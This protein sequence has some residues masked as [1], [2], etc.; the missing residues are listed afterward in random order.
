MKMTNM[1]KSLLIKKHNMISLVI[2]FK[3][4]IKPNSMEMKQKGKKALKLI[5][6]RFAA[7]MRMKMLF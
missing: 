1:R 4:K 3:K 5:T 6:T 7:A 2:I